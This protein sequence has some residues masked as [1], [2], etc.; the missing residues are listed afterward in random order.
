MDNIPGD[1]IILDNKI[2]QYKKDPLFIDSNTI[3]YTAINKIKIV[4]TASSMMKRLLLPKEKE[5][6]INALISD[7][8]EV[9]YINGLPLLDI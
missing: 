2:W 9:P 8:S 1:S 4:V 3:V 5:I 6:L 7:E